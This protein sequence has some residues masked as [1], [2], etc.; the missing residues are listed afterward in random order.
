MDILGI[1]LK[2]GEDPCGP[3][4]LDHQVVFLSQIRVNSKPPVCPSVGLEEKAG[5]C[6]CGVEAKWTQI[7]DLGTESAALSG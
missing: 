7:W 6:P 3:S 2:A 1:H 5:N 4:F